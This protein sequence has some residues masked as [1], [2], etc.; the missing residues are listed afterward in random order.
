MSKTVEFQQQGNL[1]L[2]KAEEEVDLRAIFYLIKHNF[3]FISIITLICVLL[4]FVY[5]SRIAPVYQSRA[6][7]EVQAS[8][9]SMGR[10]MDTLGFQSVPN[11]FNR[12][13][14]VNTETT[15]LQSP[16]ILAPVIEKLGLDLSASPKYFPLLGKAFATLHRG[17]HLAAPFMGLSSY[18]WGGEQIKLDLFQVSSKLVGMR[19]SLVM[20][21]NHRFELLA[22][23]GDKVLEG[24]AGELL[25]SSNKKY[26][27][28][29]KL[30]ELKGLP[31]TRFSV[32]KQAADSVAKG[33]VS[34]LSI[35]QKGKN[36]GI[37]QL[38][39]TASN[40]EQAQKILD[41]IVSVAVL[42][43]IEK[44]SA[45]SK[46]SLG[47]LAHQIPLTKSK[48]T[49]AE[50]KLNQYRSEH[51][52]LNAKAEASSILLDISHTGTALDK[53]KLQKEE[54]LQ[55]F[56][57]IHP[58]VIAVNLRIK[59]L[60]RHEALLDKRLRRLPL[61]EQ[62]IEGLQ[63]DIKMRAKI[64][65][66][67]LTTMQKLQMS[68]GGI[69]SDVSVLSRASYP[70]G[71]TPTKKAPVILGS[72][73]AGLILSIA[74]LMLRKFLSPA[75]ED[76]EVVEKALNL[77][78]MA[79]LPFSSAQKEMSKTMLSSKSKRSEFDD[80]PFVLAREKPKDL[81]IE[82]LRS[83]RTALK[84]RLIDSE[85]NLVSVTGSSPEIGKSFICV[86][87]ATLF[88]DAGMRV[89]LVDTDIRKGHIARY[90]GKPKRPGLSEYLQ[91]QAEV[92]QI[93]QM[94]TP[95]KFDFISTGSYPQQPSELLMKPELEHL[96][97]LLQKN[98]DLV[99][100]DTSPLLAVTDAA[101][102]LKHSSVNLLTIGVG[103]DQL[104]EIEYAKSKLEK[105]GSALQGLI[106]NNLIF[107]KHG[108]G[109][110]YGYG[111]YNYYYS[112]DR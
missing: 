46:K 14:P 94:V 102:V 70:I 39:F 80:R 75:I 4:G 52:V 101:I 110:G 33:F 45:E 17:D 65:A 43:N 18:A 55:K 63:G 93:V 82:A 111:G 2:G 30:A 5:I 104:K 100:L 56:T 112:Y 90:L 83:L 58:F 67:V 89:I 86:N 7:I 1:E 73:I 16:Y 69:V 10:L 62:Q 49:A 74:F 31:G 26:P 77:P 9:G 78:A 60:T 32:Q 84:L 88:A 81:A 54:L 22:P 38:G 29:I 64:Y 79:I 87:L 27:L 99:L 47:F 98:Y 23:N 85:N 35:V 72:L 92:S 109:Y 40:P 41:T 97:A 6:L 106:F 53:L 20:Q 103:K 28:S 61:S 12:A 108:D 11:A 48:L 71:P 8:G 51:G 68:N 44:K 105:T 24:K 76:P 25:H 91:G 59:D 13:N 107:S 36:T 3:K 19:F 15:L 95:D 42:R 34:S 66:S 96:L 37:L 57:S 50:G 21:S